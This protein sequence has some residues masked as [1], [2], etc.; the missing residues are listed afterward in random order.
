MDKPEQSQGL[1]GGRL[2]IAVVT[3]TYPPEI[4]GVAATVGTMVRGLRARGHRIEVIRP[5]QISDRSPETGSRV[6]EVL[7]R[8]LPIPGYGSLR[9]GMPATGKSVSITG[10]TLFRF[11]RGLIQ[12]EWSVFNEYSIM[13]QLGLIPTK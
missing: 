12:E 2:D 6:G 1:R 5:K 3:E 10:M 11:E 9:M 8:G 4:N 13:K 7:V